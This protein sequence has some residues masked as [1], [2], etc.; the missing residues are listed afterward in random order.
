MLHGRLWLPLAILC[1][2]IAT[3][4]DGLDADLLVFLRELLEEN[5]A[6]VSSLNKWRSPSLAGLLMWL[7]AP[8]QALEYNMPEGV[9]AI[10]REIFWL[11]NAVFWITVAVGVVVFGAMGWA[12]F[13]HRRSVHPTPSKFDDNLALEITWTVVAA[14]ILVVIAWPSTTTLIAAED[15]S[16]SQLTIEARGY[17]WRWQ[18]KYLDQDH[19]PQ[20]SFFSSMAT[21]EDERY[22]REAKGE[23]YL[24]EVDE[25]MVIPV[26]TKVRFLITSNDTIHAFWVPDFGIKS[27]AIPGYVN[28]LWTLVDQVGVYR[29][30][31]TELCGAFHGFMPIVVSVVEQ[32]EYESWYAD[33]VVEQERVKALVSQEWTAEQL[34]ARGEGVYQQFCV[35]CHQANGQGIPPAFPSLVKT[36]L[37]KDK[38][39]HIDIVYHGKAGTAMQ[40]FKDQLGTVDL[41]AV[42]HYERNAWGND[43]GDVTGPIDILEFEKSQQ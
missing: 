13:F 18:Y 5:C 27:D 17:Q 2:T 20:L 19:Q 8:A 33:K 31:C 7:A 32:A 24:L 6:L 14:L 3:S 36:Q 37:L 30:Q 12:M 29:G 22:N 39:G 16:E 15:T 34:Y 38:R 41:A 42:I 43:A 10:S 23:Y 4:Y 28:E 35:A 11:H 21:S 26:N 25:P 1:V 40:A 9:T